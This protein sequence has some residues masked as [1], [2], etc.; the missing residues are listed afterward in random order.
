MLYSASGP[1]VI[2]RVPVRGRQRGTAGDVITGGGRG[3]KPSAEAST[4]CKGKPP[5]EMQPC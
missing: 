5:E 4:S 1:Y 2:I 3:H